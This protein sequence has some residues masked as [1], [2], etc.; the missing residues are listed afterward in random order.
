MENIKILVIDDDK[1]IVQSIQEV[2]ELA[3]YDTDASYSGKDAIER[4]KD[5][6]F[7]VVLCDIMLPDILG[8]E[9]LANIH[10]LKPRVKVI[11]ITGFASLDNAVLSLNLGA[12]AYIMKPVNPDNLLKV[13]SN[14]LHE[15]DKNERLNEDRVSEWIEDRLNNLDKE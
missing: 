8:T 11:M 3:G 5:E 4:I 7:N 12:S 14:K 6:D 9:V 10:K 1:M 2:L 13:I 15:Q